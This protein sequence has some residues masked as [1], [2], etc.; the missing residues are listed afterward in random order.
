MSHRFRPPFRP[1]N[2]REWV[3]WKHE[4]MDCSLYLRFSVSL[5]KLFVFEL[6]SH[7]MWSIKSFRFSNAPITYMYLH[8]WGRAYLRH[9]TLNDH[10]QLES[11]HDVLFAKITRQWKF[12][13]ILQSHLD[14]LPL[15]GFTISIIN[16][17]P[18]TNNTATWL[19][20]NQSLAV[21]H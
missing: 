19:A 5:G 10:N 15:I 7:L 3:T 4:G 8:R 17:I 13:E 11:I 21:V 9:V 1:R 14:I 2:R 16:P 6:L 18:C 12:K 20:I